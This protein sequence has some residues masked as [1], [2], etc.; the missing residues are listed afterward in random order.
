VD[1]AFENGAPVEISGVPM[2][3]AEL[4][5]CLDTIAG[6]HG[7]GR[8][9]GAGAPALIVLHAAHRALQESTGALE[10]V[11]GLVRLEL[12][13]GDCRVTGRHVMA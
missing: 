12:F 10:P 5:V 9:H 7:V 1:I 8:G 11:S 6:G 13:K 3:V 4:V 2:S